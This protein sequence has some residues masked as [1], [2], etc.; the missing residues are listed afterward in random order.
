MCPRAL[1][2]SQTMIPV[3]RAGVSGGLWHLIDDPFSQRTAAVRVS[4]K[5]SAAVGPDGQVVPQQWLAHTMAPGIRPHDRRRWDLVV[6]GATLRGGAL[7]CDATPVSLLTRA[8]QPQPGAAET[9]GS[10]LRTAERCKHA[11]YPELRRA[12]PQ[13][14]L[15]LGSK[16][17]G[18][19]NGRMCKHIRTWG[20]FFV[21]TCVGNAMSITC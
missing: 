14:L 12:G 19:W 2:S 6:Y 1:P 9:D 20:L 15:V 21:R 10:A 16:F 4:S 8:G 17:G 11:T 3:F 5:F 18:R 7:C 13:R